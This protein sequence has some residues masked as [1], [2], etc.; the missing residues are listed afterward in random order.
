MPCER[1]QWR[2]VSIILL[3]VGAWWSINTDA[4]S[5][6]ENEVSKYDSPTIRHLSLA[7]RHEGPAA[8]NVFWTHTSVPLIEP[9]EREGEFRW[10]TFLWRGD[11]TTREVSV[12][13]G[14]VPTPDPS[15]WTF[16]RL[17]NSDLWF[18]TDRVP[19]D[20]RFT[21]LLRV[22]GGPLQPDPLNRRQFGGRSI[23]EL[24]DAP[25]QPWI[26][27]RPGAPKG[28]LTHQV[29]RS[30]VLQEDRLIGVYT[31]PGYSGRGKP[32]S[33]VIVFDG[34]VYGDSHDA[35]VPTPRVLDNLIAANRI[36]PT[37]A[38][39]VD[40]MSQKLRYRDLR[41][42]IAFESFIAS[43]LLPWVRAHYHV[44]GKPSDVLVTG[45]SDG[46]LFA[47]FAGLHDPEAFGNVLAQSSNLFYSPARKPTLNAY[48]RDG[49]WL[50]RQFVT[51]PLLPLRFYLD[52]GLLEAGVTN[53][54]FEHRRL[55][56]ALEA[57]GYAV[58]YNEFSGGHDYI[59]W[60]NS[61]GDGLIALLGHGGSR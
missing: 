30:R 28:E 18:K 59:D 22:N 43:E 39:L 3:A 29:L 41:C 37:I 27:D 4:Q 44:S 35:L 11:A 55:R 53:P 47:I 21:Y 61:L 50:T 34:E 26:A 42:S 58:T 60:R 7:L 13:S 33:L 49:G 2:A 14:D 5:S 36:P 8:L 24:P 38:V 15:K 16:K 20:A 46:G 9:I 57:K 10:I 48:T 19:K 25:P 51:K 52:V 54:V 6:T 56:D 17:G 12:G 23:V 31:P 40:N 1:L 32:N 45:S